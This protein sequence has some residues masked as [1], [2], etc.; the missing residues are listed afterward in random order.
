MI[1]RRTLILVAVAAA[2]GALPAFAQAARLNPNTAAAAQLG[3]LAGL[4]RPLAEA[5]QKRR[6]FASMVEFDALVRQV[7]NA[8]QAAALYQDVFIPVNLNTGKREEMALIPGMSSRMV[9]EFLEYRP[10]RDIEVFNREIGKYVDDAEVA[11][12]RSYVT[13]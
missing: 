7:L 6:P 4:T 12:L 8:E 13:L 10:Y 5:I 2:L 3:K 11:R 1:A 9:R